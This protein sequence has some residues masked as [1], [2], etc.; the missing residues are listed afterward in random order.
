MSGRI[1]KQNLNNNQIWQLN[2]KIGTFYQKNDH[3]NS[4]FFISYHLHDLI[5]TFDMANN[6]NNPLEYL[7]SMLK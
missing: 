1:E 4:L 3:G 6:N 2:S 7:S 5:G